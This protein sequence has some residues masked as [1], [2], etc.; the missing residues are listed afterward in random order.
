MKP[1]NQR[2][3][4]EKRKKKKGVTCYFEARNK[5]NIH[6]SYHSNEF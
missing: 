1:T 5:R 4:S 6:Y 3:G 2:G